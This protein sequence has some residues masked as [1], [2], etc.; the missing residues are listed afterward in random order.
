LLLAVGVAGAAA[1]HRATHG[2]R[3]T[4]QAAVAWPAHA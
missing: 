1:I 2:T 3:F 4:R